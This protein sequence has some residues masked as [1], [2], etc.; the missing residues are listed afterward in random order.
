[1]LETV[2][3]QAKALYPNVGKVVGNTYAPLL[4]IDLGTA[5]NSV[6]LASTW[7]FR[8]KTL[9]ATGAAWTNNDDSYVWRVCT[10]R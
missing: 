8:I 5:M 7:Q 9:D 1:M 4:T 2:D 6:N 3:W 10:W